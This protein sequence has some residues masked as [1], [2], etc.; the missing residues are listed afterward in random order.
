MNDDPETLA[1]MIAAEVALYSH[2]DNAPCPYCSGDGLV[3]VGADVDC[4]DGVNGP[5]EGDVIACPC[6]SDPGDAA[7]ETY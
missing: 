5:F 4:E 1:Q 3:L 7:Y 2:E 6:C